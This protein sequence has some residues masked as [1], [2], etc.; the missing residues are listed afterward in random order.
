MTETGLYISDQTK[1]SAKLADDGI[2]RK[3]LSSSGQSN[4][5][6]KQTACKVAVLLVEALLSTAPLALPED[7]YDQWPS[8]LASAID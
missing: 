4:Q 6:S 8:L 5:T 7:V 2:L 1:Q 3:E